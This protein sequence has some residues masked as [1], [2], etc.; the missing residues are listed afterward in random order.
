MAFGVYGDFQDADVINLY[1]NDIFIKARAINAPELVGTQEVTVENIS[2]DVFQAGDN[3]IVARLERGGREVLRTQAFRLIVQ[4]P[5]AAPAIAVLADRDEQTIA[6][7]VTGIFEEYDTVRVFLGGSEIASKE[8]SASDAS[9]KTIR[10]DGIAF[11]V[12]QPGEN[13]FTASIMRGG[14]EGSQS[15]QS[16]PV[17]IEEESEEITE[18]LQCVRYADS[19]NK[20]VAQNQDS[21]DGFGA[22]LSIHRSTLAVGG[23]GDDVYVYTKGL[24]R[25]WAHAATL[26]DES[27]VQSGSVVKSVA[28]YDRTTVLVGNPQSSYRQGQSGAVYS[29]NKNQESWNAGITLAPADLIAQEA[30]GTHI[31]LDNRLLVVG[32]PHRDDSG[33]V[34]VYARQN[35]TWGTP[36]RAALQDT[37]SD[38]RFGYRVSVSGDRVAVGVPG[39]GIGVNGAVHIYTRKGDSW[40]TNTIVPRQRRTNAQF[41]SAV[42]L[43]GNT[44]LVSAMR[45]D[46]GGSKLNSGVVY[47]YTISDDDVRL[48]QKLL[49]RQDDG[50]GAFGM[51]IA[52]SGGVLAIGAPRSD[53]VKENSGAVYVYTRTEGAGE[54]WS[55]NQIVTPSNARAGDRFGSSIVFDGIRLIIGAYGVDDHEDNAGAVYVY[56]VEAV[57]C[58]ETAQGAEKPQ[59]GSAV[60][61]PEELL[62]DLQKK[63]SIFETFA[64]RVSDIANQFN[65]SIQDVYETIRKKEENIVVF[66]ESQALESAQRR[67]AEMRGIIGPGLPG[68]VV[69]RSVDSPEDIP[70]SPTKNT[71]R[72]RDVV[73]QETQSKLGSVVPFGSTDLR[74]GDVHEDVYRLQVFLNRNDYPVGKKGEPGSVGNEVSVFNAATERAVRTFQIV[75]G[76]PVTGAFDKKTRDAILAHLRTF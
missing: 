47:V 29:Y 20:I 69:V 21:F 11:D 32:A 23:R 40:T 51:A 46:Q 70:E 19:P 1:N 24:D 55:L 62:Q 65:S 71:V 10:I 56:D 14:H 42:L 48:V 41:G 67:A 52:H 33:A 22:S 30:F 4:E 34:Y 72:S 63:K 60:L 54:P 38:Q 50:D 37:A 66:D 9:K 31:A 49:P 3:L 2:S 6:V 17:V 5:P 64:S 76:L 43:S 36:F 15:K 59:S 16:A 44:L 28:V 12:L 8:I 35:N 7:D 26:T 61:T 27:F 57:A 53:A 58:P 75:N 68:E 45:D 74:L 39:D 25:T 13:F 18:D 73:V